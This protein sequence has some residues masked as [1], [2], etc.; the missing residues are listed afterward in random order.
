MKGVKNLINDRE[1]RIQCYYQYYKKFIVDTFKAYDK[2]GDSK[3]SMKEFV[4]MFEESWKTAFRFVG[5]V[6]VKSG[7]QDVKMAEINQ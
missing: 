5:Q 4:E 7:H 1:T 3:V 6:V 2:D